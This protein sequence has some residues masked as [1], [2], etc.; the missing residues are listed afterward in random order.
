[1]QPAPGSSPAPVVARIIPNAAAV[2]ATWN[3]VL[4]DSDQSD[5][6]SSSLTYDS[7]AGTVDDADTPVRLPDTGPWVEGEDGSHY[8]TY[9][10]G[11]DD[12]YSPEGNSPTE[13]QDGAADNVEQDVAHVVNLTQDG[14]HPVPAARLVFSADSV[15]VERVD[16]DYENYYV[17][18]E[19]A[20][21]MRILGQKVTIP[22][23]RSSV[24]RILSESGDGANAL[25]ETGDLD[26]GA[27]AEELL[28]IGPPV[29]VYISRAEGPAVLAA[30]QARRA[31]VCWRCA[32]HCMPTVSVGCMVCMY[33]CWLCTPMP[34]V[35]WVCGRRWTG[36]TPVQ[37][38]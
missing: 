22:G 13:V 1:M 14:T 33:L 30:I 10:G 9:G 24:A 18:P 25:S 31:T 28:L 19:A 32:L 37:R 16:M 21:L 8:E 3:V 26:N 17:R 11:V 7:D 2:L 5:T 34:M 6:P 27:T 4:R 15:S 38:A 35:V 29:R 36:A 12:D 23:L 20:T